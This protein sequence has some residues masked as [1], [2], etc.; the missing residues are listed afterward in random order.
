MMDLVRVENQWSRPRSSDMLAKIASRMAGT[1]AM[2][3]NRL[4]M[5]TCSCAPAIL[6]A[7]GKPKSR[8]LPGD[9]HHHRQHEH[10]VEE[11]HPDHDEVGRHDGREPGQDDVG[12]K[13]GAERQDHD[14]QADREGQTAPVA[15]H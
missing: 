10:E 13:A 5:R 7:A 14:D 4:T 1:T 8:H 6:A 2:T 3:L 9:D 12:R 11:Q 15:P